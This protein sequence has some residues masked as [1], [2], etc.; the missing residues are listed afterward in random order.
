M[1]GTTYGIYMS[2]VL[3]YIFQKQHFVPVSGMAYAN[4]CLHH[5]KI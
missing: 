1:T 2:D 3:P 5:N 4:A